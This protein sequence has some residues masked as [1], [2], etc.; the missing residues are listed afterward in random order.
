MIRREQSEASMLSPVVLPVSFEISGCFSKE[1]GIVFGE[2]EHHIAVL[3]QQF[4]HAPGSMAMVNGKGS[5]RS[6][7]ARACGLWFAAKRAYAVLTRKHLIVLR[8][9]QIE[10]LAKLARPFL[11]GVVCAW[12]LP[13][14]IWMGCVILCP[15]NYFTNLAHTPNAKTQ[16]GSAIRGEFCK[17]LCFLA[18]TAFLCL[19]WHWHFFFV[20]RVLRVAQLAPGL[21][22]IGVCSVSSKVSKRF[23]LVTSVALFAG[24]LNKVECA[25][26]DILG[27]TG[28]VIRT[29]ILVNT[30]G[31]CYQH[32]LRQRHVYLNST[33]NPLHKQVYGYFASGVST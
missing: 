23:C 14:H 4:T 8:R 32:S 21:L 7:V 6:L 10:L 22:F 2:A 26:R 20:P 18:D 31:G 3:A 27:Y 24:R 1:F 25:L 15:R 12:V 33:T 5:C 11:F 28:H 9:G 17:Q 30:P 16:P 29:P 19:P 13:I